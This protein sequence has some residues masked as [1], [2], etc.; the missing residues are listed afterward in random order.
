MPHSSPRPCVDCR[1]ALV[2]SADGLCDPC[3]SKRSASYN[4]RRHGGPADDTYYHSPE[5][6]RLRAE[7]LIVEPLCR[8]CL[9]KP[10]AG[11][12]CHHIIERHLGGPDT[13]SNLETLCKGHL[14]GADLR[15][16]AARQG[17]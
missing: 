2:K 12:G 6:T 4:A 9:P 17:G 1:V 11:Y 10:V 14:T 15:G 5:W 7:H 3:R 13:H 16:A 8:R